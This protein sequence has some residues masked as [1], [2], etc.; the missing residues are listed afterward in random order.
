[1]LS[2]FSA[3]SLQASLL[4]SASCSG[5]N[6]ET[7][8]LHSLNLFSSKSVP[9]RSTTFEERPTEQE[10]SI[11]VNDNNMQIAFKILFILSPKK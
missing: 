8:C 2:N 6:S 11:T 3:I 1:M 9:I 10:V 4:I 5:F 7:Y